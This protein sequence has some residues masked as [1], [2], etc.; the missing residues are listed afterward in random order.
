MNNKKLATTAFLI[1]GISHLSYLILMPLFEG[2]I[3]NI[4]SI[5]TEYLHYSLS[6]ALALTICQLSPMLSFLTIADK[7]KH[8]HKKAGDLDN[9]V[10]KLF[11][12]DGLLISSCVFLHSSNIVNV[13]SLERYISESFIGVSLI[14][15]VC[16]FYLVTSTNNYI[17]SL[18]DKIKVYVTNR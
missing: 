5:K 9:S 16:S 12:A 7:L 18:N 6:I 4:D 8:K 17:N 1:I 3:Y 2:S 14:L 15:A 10:Y 13:F 11:S